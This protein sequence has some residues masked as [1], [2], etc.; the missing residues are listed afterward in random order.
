M[1]LA[2]ENNKSLIIGASVVDGRLSISEIDPKG[3]SFSISWI[4][5]ESWETSVIDSQDDQTTTTIDK[6]GDGLP[7]LRV[8]MAD[9]ALLR[10]TLD[11][12]RWI[13]LKSKNKSEQGVA[14]QSATRSESNSGGGD[15]SQPE[16]K[17]RSR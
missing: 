14:P 7:D 4:D 11:D 8:V 16:S 2:P 13:E 12:P 6:N 1:I 10:S 17:P 5:E 3:R 9:G 15:N